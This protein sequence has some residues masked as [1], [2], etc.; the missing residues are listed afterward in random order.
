MA[1]LEE[2]FALA[3]AESM[4]KSS[5]PAIR[6]MFELLSTQDHAHA[7]LLRDSKSAKQLH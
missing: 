1:D 3:H 6:Q 4:A 2:K 7:A 5:D